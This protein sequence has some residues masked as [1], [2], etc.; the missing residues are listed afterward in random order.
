MIKCDSE[1]VKI[2]TQFF[3]TFLGL[4]FNFSL[5]ILVKLN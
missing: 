2:L 3:H 1:N 5:A 4:M